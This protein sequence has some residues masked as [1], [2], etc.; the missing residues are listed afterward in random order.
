MTDAHATGP[1]IVDLEL[2]PTAA[3]RVQLP[4]A[5]VDVGALLDRHLPEVFHRVTEVDGIPAGAPYARYFEFGPDRADIEMGIPLEGV[6]APL[7]GL[8][9]C[10]PG[11]VGASE[12]PGGPA[13]H[14]VHRGPYDTLSQEYERLHD[15][16]HEQGREE[17]AGPWESYVDDP[18]E[19]AD[20]AE[21]RTDVYW[22]LGKT[23]RGSS[24]MKP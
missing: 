19:V 18:T 6:P 16:I 11:E 9:E 7:R 8:A 24:S 13:A 20:S 1:R 15:W 3:V 10:A 4:M 23:R 22:P 21:L 2:Q 17:G 14:A 12:L 5:D